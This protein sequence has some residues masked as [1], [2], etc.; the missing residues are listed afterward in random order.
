MTIL[1]KV[2]D[3]YTELSISWFQ[4][5]GADFVL[6]KSPAFVKIDHLTTTLLIKIV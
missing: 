6:V 5:C 1:V 4:K 2:T 3:K